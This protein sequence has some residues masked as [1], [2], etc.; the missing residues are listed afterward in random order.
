MIRRPP[1]STP[2]Y[3]SAASDVYKRQTRVGPPHPGALPP[4]AD[5]ASFVCS[6][7]QSNQGSSAS[8]SE[9]STVDP[10][11]SRR[12]EGA[13]EYALMSYATPSSSRIPLTR[14]ATLAC[15]SPG[16]AANHGSTI[17]KQM[18]VQERSEGSSARKSTQSVSSTQAATAS[19]LEPLRSFKTSNP[20]RSSAQRRPSK[21]SS[22]QSIEGVFIVEPS[23][24]PSLRLP[25][26]SIR[27]ILG[28][29]RG[30]S[31]VS[32]RSTA[33]GL[34]INIPCW[35]SPPITF[36]HEYVHTSSLSK[37]TSMAK[38]AEVA[39][40]IVRPSRSSGIQLP[41]GTRTPEV[42]PFQVNTTSREKSA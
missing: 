31:K 6:Q 16:N 32:R 35:A 24:M 34:R 5:S 39:S 20:P 23:K 40:Q 36:C 28:R 27:N 12:P 19:R 30:G 42:V 26:L 14:L 33:R 9:R 11:H 7:A 17:L 13:A 21:A 37:V 3:S 25:P 4:Y 2:L 22:T 15:S 8:V 18:D 1:R 10:P 41:P 29:G 38:I